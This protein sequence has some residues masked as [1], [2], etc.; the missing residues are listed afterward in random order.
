MAPAQNVWLAPRGPQ[1]THQTFWKVPLLLYC[2]WLVGVTLSGTDWSSHTAP[3]HRIIIHSSR[4]RTVE[5]VELWFSLLIIAAWISFNDSS[6]WL[7][8]FFI[9]EIFHNSRVIRRIQHNK[10]Y[11]KFRDLTRTWT[12]ITCLAVSHS[13]RYTRMFSKLL[14]DCNWVLFMHGWFCP[15]HL[16]GRKSLHFEKKLECCC[17]VRWERGEGG[18]YGCLAYFVWATKWFCHS[19]IFCSFLHY[20]SCC[21]KITYNIIS[22]FGNYQ[23]NYATLFC[24]VLC[25]VNFIRKNFIAVWSKAAVVFPNNPPLRIFF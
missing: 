4:D 7:S 14:W 3:V 25:S 24:Y 20:W 6:C 1:E 2:W 23:G 17:R 21:R 15:I 5:N 11:K 12:Q 18:F 9:I 10:I 8:T 13:N 16:I 19:L 22:S